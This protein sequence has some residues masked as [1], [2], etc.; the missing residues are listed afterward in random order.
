MFS[1][2]SISGGG[3]RGGVH[4][5]EPK[6]HFDLYPTFSFLGGYIS[7]KQNVTL[8]WNPTFSFLEGVHQPES[9]CHLDLRFQLFH[10]WGEYISQKQN[11]TLTWNPTFS[12]LGE[13]H[14]LPILRLNMNAKE[15]IVS[16]V[17]M[18]KVHLPHAQATGNCAISLTITNSSD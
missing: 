7:Q 16:I 17:F 13:G 18:F 12:F 8:T 4:Q 9:K 15:S 11:V 10:S 6:C 1:P 14:C 2:I 3:G 5:P